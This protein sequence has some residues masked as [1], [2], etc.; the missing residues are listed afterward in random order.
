TSGAK[1]FSDHAGAPT[2]RAI[3]DN[4]SGL[5]ELQKSQRTE[6]PAMQQ[7]LDA[8]IRIIELS[9]SL[10]VKS[11]IFCP[12]MVYGKGEGF[13]NQVSIQTVAIV[14]TAKATGR[15]RDLNKSDEAAWPVCHVVDN[16]LLYI[17]ILRTILS[18]GDCGHGRNG[19]YL[20]SSGRVAWKDVY[21]S[22]STALSKRGLIEASGVYPADDDF[23][24]RM[25]EALNSPKEMVAPQLSGECTFAAKYGYEIGWRPSFQPEHILEAMDDEVDLILASNSDKSERTQKKGAF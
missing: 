16:A 3:A 17:A 9:E 6:L 8:N 12:C 20:A 4:E 7:L 11:Y 24:A 21:A 14:S 2:D 10:G 1:A 25:A 19:F 18:S 13:G 22:I 15:V 5:F 23:L